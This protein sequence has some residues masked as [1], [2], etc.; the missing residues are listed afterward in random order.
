MTTG[1]CSS[2]ACRGRKRQ[3]ALDALSG[4]QGMLDHDA[5]LAGLVR[6]SGRIPG[7]DEE[8]AAELRQAMAEEERHRSHNHFARSLMED[9]WCLFRL[10]A[11]F[12]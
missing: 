11:N 4:K 7:E 2:C 12:S 10:P 1:T 6:E 5:G 3:A 8:F 9:R